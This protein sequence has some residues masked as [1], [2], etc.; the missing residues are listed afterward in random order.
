MLQIGHLICEDTTADI[1]ELGDERVAQPIEDE[2]AGPPALDDAGAAEDPELLGGC[3]RFHLELSEQVLHAHLAITQELEHAQP[4][5]MSHRLEEH[6]LEAV[7]R[8]PAGLRRLR[9]TRAG[10]MNL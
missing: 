6:G 5:R 9:Q 1:E 8:L 10:F 3:R 4:E 2:A 7:K